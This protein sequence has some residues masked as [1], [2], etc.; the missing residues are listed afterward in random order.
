MCD[1]LIK[2]LGDGDNEIEKK[3]LIAIENKDYDEA[4]RLCL[5][6]PCNPYLAAIL[7]LLVPIAHQ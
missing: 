3:A 4:K 6:D 7:V 1:C 5:C 2:E